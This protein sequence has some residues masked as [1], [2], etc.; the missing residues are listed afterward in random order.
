MKHPARASVLGG[1]LMASGDMLGVGISGLLAFQRALATTGHNIANVNTAGYSRQRVELVTQTPQFAG[2]GYIGTGVRADS[3]KRLYDDFLTLQVRTSTSSYNRLD[4][5][6]NMASQVDGLLAD[7]QTGLAP[8]LQG[9]S[10]PCRAWPTT[11][12]RYRRARRC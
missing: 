12:R 1:E 9:F 2:N 6:H 4:R 7:S 3:I 8:A 10:M 11:R 5:Y